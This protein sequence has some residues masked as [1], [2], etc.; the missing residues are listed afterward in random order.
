MRCSLRVS[1]CGQVLFTT[2]VTEL[3]ARILTLFSLTV[4]TKLAERPQDAEMLLGRIVL[5]IEDALQE[6]ST[7]HKAWTDLYAAGHL[8]PVEVEII[9]K[10]ED[11]TACPPLGL[12]GGN[13]GSG[14]WPGGGGGGGGRGANGNGSGGN[15]AGGALALFEY[16]NVGE[17]IDVQ[18]FVS[19]GEFGWVCPHGTAS[20]DV[21][22]IG[23]GGGGNGAAKRTFRLADG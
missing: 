11:G 6:T 16:S 19:P 18:P 7:F 14:A 23:G 2:P 13:G 1:Q 9:V 12:Y 10:N 3:Y 5:T 15:G 4:P 20:I 21:V 17:M 22:A 8:N